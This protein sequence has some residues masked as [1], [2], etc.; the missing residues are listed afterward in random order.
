MG[1]HHIKNIAKYGVKCVVAI[2]EFATDTKAE[3]ECVRE[4]ALAAGA[5]DA[6]IA[7]H[8]AEGGAG[9]VDL[10]T[11]VEAC[12][13]CKAEGSPFKFLYPLEMRLKEKIEKIC[14]EMYG[15]DGVD[16]SE[17]AE[18]RLASYEAAGLSHLPICMAKTQYS[19]S[20]DPK[21]KGVPTGFRVAIRDVRAAAGAGYIYPIAGDIMTI[22]GL[23]TRPGFYD[24]DMDLDTGKVVGLF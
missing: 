14:K 1:A 22:P 20:T 11:A 5:F 17:L 18:A 10:A 9:A 3:L 24:V 6:Q 19:L 16:Y 15:A 8:W 12:K 13:A 2:N 21:A 23:P 4:M 7:R